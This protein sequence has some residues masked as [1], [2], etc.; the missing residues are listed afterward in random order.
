MFF[1]FYGVLIL[2]GSFHDFFLQEM[3]FMLW[4]VD[5]IAHF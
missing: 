5:S 2:V 4:E 3:N 1:V